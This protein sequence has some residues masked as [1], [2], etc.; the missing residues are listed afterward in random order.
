MVVV[1]EV[2]L[3]VQRWP[4]KR[5]ARAMLV[6]GI[7]DASFKKPARRIPG[8]A[9]PR[10]RRFTDLGSLTGEDS[11]SGP[12]VGNLSSFVCLITYVI[13]CGICGVSPI[14]PGH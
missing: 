7:G 13:A 12:S 14:F 1:E 5:G 2:P 4:A 8:Y 9:D 3:L 10:I 11:Y 6:A